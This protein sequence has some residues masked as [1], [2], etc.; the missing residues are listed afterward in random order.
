VRD[1][2]GRPTLHAEGRAGH[3]PAPTER[4]LPIYRPVRRWQWIGVNHNE[5]QRQIRDIALAWKARAVVVD[6]TGV[7][8]GLA[9]FLERALP[10][11]V[12]PF[13]FSTT[14]KSQL[15]WDFLSIVDSFR[16]QEPVFDD[17]PG[18]HQLRYQKE[19]F[20][21]LAACQ[22]EV[23][24]DARHSM[25]WSVPDGSRDTASGELIHDDWVLSAALCAL[26][27]KMEWGLPAETLIVKAGDPLEEMDGKY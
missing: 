14:S 15:G 17:L 23:S 25:K 1:H 27:E 4:S 5:L 13:H 20:T 24:G 26:L 10:G 22:F 7:G 16:W 11:R 8:A 6:A 3:G 2:S 18:D 19:F 12:T 21:Q 9:S